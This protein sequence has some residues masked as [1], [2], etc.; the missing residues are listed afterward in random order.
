VDGLSIRAK[1]ATSAGVSQPG[2]YLNV[3]IIQMMMMITTVRLTRLSYGC[4]VE[5]RK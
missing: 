2:P 3:V 1:N 5:H 4:G